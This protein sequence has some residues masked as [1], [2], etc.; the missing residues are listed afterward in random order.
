MMAQFNAANPSGVGQKPPKGGKRKL[1]E[2]DKGGVPGSVGVSG[3]GFDDGMD[4]SPRPQQQQQSPPQQQQQMPQQ[5]QQQ[6]P[7][8]SLPMSPISQSNNN[9][10][11]GVIMN[12]PAKQQLPGQQ[13]QQYM[14]TL[15]GNASGT[16]GNGSGNGSGS[17]SGS[18]NQNQNQHQHQQ[19]SIAVASV[20]IPA[21]QNMPSSPPPFSG[22]Y[23]TAPI[24]SGSMVSV[25]SESA[26]QEVDAL[27][28]AGDGVSLSVGA[29]A[30]SS[31]PE[32]LKRPP[33][34]Y[35]L[36]NRDM[37]HT[38]LETNPNL[39]VAEISKEIGERWRLLD[40]NNGFSEYA[41]WMT[42]NSC[43]NIL[44][45]TFVFLQQP[46]KDHYMGEALLLK[47]KHLTQ[48]PNF[49]YTRRSKAEL[50][51]AGH[52]SKSAKRRAAEQAS[53][54]AGAGGGEAGGEGGTETAIPTRDPRG[55]KKK[56]H[57]N[58][59]APKHPMSGFLFYLSHIRP[60]VVRQYPGWTVGP[61]SK[62][63]A[64]KWRAMNEAEREPWIRKAQDDK[65]RY[66][67]EMQIY[68]AAMEHGQLTASAPSPPE[69]DDHV[70]A[71]VAQM[72]NPS[73]RQPTP[74]RAEGPQQLHMPATPPQQ[75]QQT[76]AAFQAIYASQPLQFS[77]L[78]QQGGGGQLPSAYGAQR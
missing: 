73:Q 29:L 35:L 44:Y 13:S 25:A 58:P 39:T 49:V 20:S 1:D 14:G 26:A 6:F 51:E 32:R 5:Q 11:G 65:A 41:L 8:I 34:A 69:P 9:V 30:A 57:K 72:V 22:S 12:R 75:H 37:R 19:K 52:L 60:Q 46:K 33:N 54:G 27:A 70:I 61:V 16:R 77:S 10:R 38:L 74:P 18:L 76:P 62:H 56:R 50:A 4:F 71:S 21:T 36:F 17:G 67:R 48:H 7:S 31:K 47:Q 15:L 2:I 64:E 55:R 63:I 24:P 28:I 3:G 53:G 23:Q 45:I 43:P 66:A 78:E 59:M 40:K 68:S 42:S